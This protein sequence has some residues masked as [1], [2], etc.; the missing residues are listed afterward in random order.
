ML[1]NFF[2]LFLPLFLNISR[3]DFAVVASLWRAEL[4]SKLVLSDFV[5]CDSVL[6]FVMKQIMNVMN[7]VGFVGFLMNVN[8]LSQHLT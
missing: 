3:L 8:S 1:L 6:G 4:F 2:L 7:F 5:R